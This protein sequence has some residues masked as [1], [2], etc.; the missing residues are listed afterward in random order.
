V[1]YREHEEKGLLPQRYGQNRGFWRDFQALVPPLRGT[2][3]R[4]PLALL[5]AEEITEPGEEPRVM[6]IGQGRDQ[7]KVT[8][9]RLETYPL[10]PALFADDAL[11][12]EVLAEC[13]ELAEKA[14]SAL[15]GVIAALVGDLDEA[16]RLMDREPLLRNFWTGME[17]EFPSLLATLTTIEDDGSRAKEEWKGKIRTC[18]WW[19]FAPITRAYSRS[20]EEMRAAI[21]AERK[22]KRALHDLLGE[23]KE[24]SA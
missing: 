16:R 3:N 14:G 12:R 1:A 9:W 8:L 23:R 5:H 22:L 2:G 18:A 19:A 20:G 6:I 11:A 7:S 15:R 13:L 4:P 17:E 10:P 21:R 24:D